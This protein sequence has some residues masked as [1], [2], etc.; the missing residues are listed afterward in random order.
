MK[1]AL[2][3]LGCVVGSILTLA[4]GGAQFVHADNSDSDAL[5]AA[6]RIFIGLPVLAVGAVTLGLCIW[7]LAR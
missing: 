2:L 5:L 7:G 3:I 6:V 4:G 1:E